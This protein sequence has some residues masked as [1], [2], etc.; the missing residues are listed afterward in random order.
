[1][2]TDLEIPAQLDR[3]V[4]FLRQETLEVD[5]VRP[6][7]PR[8]HAQ[9]IVLDLDAG[10]LD[11]SREVDLVV[12]GFAGE[13]AMVERRARLPRLPPGERALAIPL[14]AR[15]AG[16]ACDTGWT[17]IHGTCERSDL[18]IEAL[19][20]SV[21]DLPADPL[22]GV[23]A[24]RRVE[25]CAE[26][27]ANCDDDPCTVAVCSDHRCNQDGWTGT[28]LPCTSD[29]DCGG[30]ERTPCERPFCHP[31]G[32]CRLRSLPP[33][34]R[35]DDDEDPCTVQCCREATI[36]MSFDVCGEPDVATGC[37]P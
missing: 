19:A 15:C 22:A 2:W 32:V 26:E 12:T 29:A 10:L 30:L 25:G 1:M 13:V 21:E 4:A 31:H 7:D 37:D 34:T 28:C 35:C 27:G 3:I 33:G 9:P 23:V 18:P 8:G 6:L 11:R 5:A 14:E 16:R 17:C 24:G 36:C 20:A